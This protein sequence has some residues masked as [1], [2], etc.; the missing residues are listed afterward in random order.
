MNKVELDYFK[1]MNEMDFRD[2]DKV[3]EDNLDKRIIKTR[4]VTNSKRYPD[5]YIYQEVLLYI[6]L[7]NSTEFLF[8]RGAR[9]Y[10]REGYREHNMIENKKLKDIRKFV[11][12]KLLRELLNL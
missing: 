3:V 10:G 9:H 2:I 7:E 11:K 1:W 6:I 5:G 12:G 8:Y 4:T